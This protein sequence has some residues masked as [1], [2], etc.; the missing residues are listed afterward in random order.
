MSSYDQHQGDF[1]FKYSFSGSSQNFEVF[2]IDSFKFNTTNF[3]FES[4]EGFM[5]IDPTNVIVYVCQIGSNNFHPWLLQIYGTAKENSDSS[6]QSEE[7]SDSSSD[8]SSE[9]YLNYF[10]KLENKIWKNVTFSSLTDSSGQGGTFTSEEDNLAKTK[11]DTFKSLT[12]SGASAAKYYKLTYSSQSGSISYYSSG[13]SAAKYYEF[14]NSSGSSSIIQPYYLA[15]CF[16]DE[17]DKKHTYVS[18]SGSGSQEYVVTSFKSYLATVPSFEITLKGVKSESSGLES[19]TYHTGSG[20]QANLSVKTD[21]FAEVSSPVIA[22]AVQDGQSES[23]GLGGSVGGSGSGGGETKES[24]GGEKG[25]G[26]S[27]RSNETGSQASTEA[28]HEASEQTEET[29]ESGGE[30]ENGSN[31]S[32]SQDSQDSVLQ[33]SDTSSKEATQKSADSGASEA[34]SGTPAQP[35]SP[36]EPSPQSPPSSD[37]GGTE[38]AESQDSGGTELSSTT[39]AQSSD[40]LTNLPA[41]VCGTVFGSGGLI[42]GGIL[43]YKYMG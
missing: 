37:G 34:S 7:D 21:K 33:S 12:S 35:T 9:N 28:T 6:D 5:S 17:S 41:I 38:E 30:N 39:K 2:Q 27:G 1:Y 43:I 15:S 3:T 29:V 19:V 8:P 13:A 22:S 20:S 25:L 16:K 10:F 40:S 18:V 14:T 11:L 32:H 23:G 4:N 36:S 24:E 31:P 42:G 26:G